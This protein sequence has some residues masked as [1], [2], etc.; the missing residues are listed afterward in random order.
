M[1]EGGSV[2]S[3]FY[4][5]TGDYDQNGQVTI[6]DLTP[7]GQNFEESNPEGGAW[8]AANL[9][10]QVDGDSN[11][12]INI[13]DITPI[14]QNLQNSVLGGY[15][16]YASEDEADVPDEDNGFRNGGGSMLVANL[17]GETPLA[18][19]ENFEQRSE[20]RLQFI[21]DLQGAPPA[22]TSGCG[23]LTAHRTD[24]PPTRSARWQRTSAWRPGPRA[25][26]SE[27]CHGGPG[28]APAAADAIRHRRCATH[29]PADLR[30]LRP[31]TEGF[32]FRRVRVYWFAEGGW[33]SLNLLEDARYADYR[34]FWL[35]NEQQV[36]FITYRMDEARAAGHPF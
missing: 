9:L 8:P 32:V 13:S 33:Q 31:D 4:A 6:A 11:G 10:A 23:P 18:D 25:A 15:N 16:I 12:V 36:M 35:P 34:A 2:L 19:A 7:I 26:R 22:P 1:D 30:P 17:N 24:G 5:N 3:W 28:R 27:H 21:Y 14:G 20:Q 29:G